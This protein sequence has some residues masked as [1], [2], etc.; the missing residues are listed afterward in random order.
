MMDQKVKIAAGSELLPFSGWH[1][2]ECV[3][4]FPGKDIRNKKLE[5]LGGLY[6]RGKSNL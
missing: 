2:F 4:Q 6:F 3:S 5:A 1:L